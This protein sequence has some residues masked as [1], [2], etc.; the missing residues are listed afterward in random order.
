MVM[1][2]HRIPQVIDDT[3]ILLDDANASLPSILV[4]SAGWYAW[5]NDAATS[6]FAY[7][8]AGGTLTARRERQ[9][10]HWYWYAYRSQHGDLHKA[11]LGK[12]EELTSTRLHDVAAVLTGGTVAITPASDIAKPAPPS[13]VASAHPTDLLMTKLYM[14][15]AR[16]SMVPR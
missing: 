1:A 2:R 16:S 7:H 5:L 9:H 8:S 12:S 14:P 13:S 10:D 15:P 6:S 4:G 3:L 11:Y